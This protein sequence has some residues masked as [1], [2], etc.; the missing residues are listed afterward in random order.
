MKDSSS[1]LIC[2][3]GACWELP[4]VRVFERPE[5]GVR[6]ARRCADEGELLGTA[7]RDL[8]R[9]VLVDAGLRWVDRDFVATMRREGIDV[10]VIGESSRPLRDLGVR[11][12]AGDVEVETLAAAVH[13]AADAVPSRSFSDAVPPSGRVVGV[14]SGVGSPGRTTVAVHLALESARSGISTL[15]IDA[16]V[17]GASIAQTLDLAESPSLT[18]AARL[19]GD[20]WPQPLSACLRQGPLG[21]Q[22]LAG[23]ARSELWT[24]VREE[25]WRAVIAA[26]RTDFDLVV[27]DLAAPIEE[28]EDLVYD[29]IPYRRNLVTTIGLERSDVIVEVVAADPIGLRRGVIAHR[30]LA[31]NRTAPRPEVSL[32]L[33]RAP[34]AGRRLQD[35]S[36]AVSEWMGVA[37]AAILP[38]EP[39]LARSVWEGRPLHDVAPRSRWLRE[40]RV[41][42]GEVGA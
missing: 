32:V 2:A 11:T 12:F 40:L 13:G 1:V 10:L 17:W 26:A 33:N 39:A 21:V 37:P 35:C 16:D 29:R 5:L 36:R 31:S 42:A 28:D 34:A 23:L 7:L 30:T 3:G 27:L 8:P 6:L 38:E 4:L 14:W 9:A 24:E 25:A 18:Q 15:L 19:A 41:F 22:V 20:G